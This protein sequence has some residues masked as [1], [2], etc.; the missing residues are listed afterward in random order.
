M[1]SGMLCGVHKILQCQQPLQ[2]DI[3]DCRSIIIDPSIT[4]MKRSHLLITWGILC[5]GITAVLKWVC[6]SAMRHHQMEQPTSLRK[7]DNF[8]I[9]NFICALFGQGLTPGCLYVSE[10]PTGI[11]NHVG[12]T[13]TNTKGNTAQ[14]YICQVYLCYHVCWDSLEFMQLLV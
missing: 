12:K 13:M 4:I 2:K 8:R 7:C 9:T 3:M 14:C 6:P 10:I 11:L 1:S 5:C